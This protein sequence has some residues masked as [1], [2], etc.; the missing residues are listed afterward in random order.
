MTQATPES[1]PTSTTNRPVLQSEL[2]SIRS[3][4]MDL[5]QQVE[6]A[7]ERSIWGCGSA[8]LTSAPQ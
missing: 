3:G 4:V 2:D 6:V 1:A 7:I 8:T 5:A